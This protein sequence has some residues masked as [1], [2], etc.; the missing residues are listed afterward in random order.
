MNANT[1]MVIV[2]TLG[3]I[4]S[5]VSAYFARGSKNEAQASKVTAQQANNATHVGLQEIKTMVDGTL[6]ASKRA[7]LAG[8]KRELV[9]LQNAIP[10]TKFGNAIA[11]AQNRIA[12]LER[13][14]EIRVETD[15]LSRTQAVDT[16]KQIVNQE[17][18]E[19]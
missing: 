12:E 7:E 9:L 8:L 11:S 14:I 2:A 6:T 17:K 4:S 13:E 19:K 5:M 1:A 15:N 18:D 10:S 3:A 16:L